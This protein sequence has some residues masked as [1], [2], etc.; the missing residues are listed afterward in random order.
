MSE[1]DK[2][3]QFITRDAEWHYERRR[4]ILKNHPE[5]KKYC[6][7]WSMS[8]L[9]LVFMIYFRFMSMFWFLTNIKNL[10]FFNTYFAI[11]A[12]SLFVDQLLFH[13]VVTFSHEHSHNLIFDTTW[14]IILVDLTLEFGGFTFGSLLKYVYT[15]S[16]F[17]HPF[18]GDVIKDSEL[19]S[20][21]IHGIHKLFN[22]LTVFI[23]G[24]SLVVFGYKSVSSTKM[25]KFTTNFIYRKWACR[26]ASLSSFVFMFVHGGWHAILLAIWT[27]ALYDS[28]WSFW[29]KGQSIAEHIT[30]NR[31]PTFT[32]PALFHNLVF[33]NTGY[34]DEHHTFPMIPWIY[35]PVLK[36]ISPDIFTH[37][38]HQ[39]YAFLWF[40][41]FLAEFPNYRRDFEQTAYFMKKTYLKK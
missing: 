31:T 35:L 28:V 40:R 30:S 41:W 22:I 26:L 32:S 15:H 27:L 11:G 29:R 21:D 18:T 20:K 36:N 6:G 38:N 10:N 8:Y 19:V 14:G 33:F 24:L 5:I 16:R 13:S 23:P 12:Y 2:M 34:H 4:K 25:F 9:F 1:G 39:P 3:L 17:H 37:E 7:S